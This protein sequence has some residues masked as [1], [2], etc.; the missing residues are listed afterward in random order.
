[1]KGG[2]A[3][4]NSNAL[5]FD[6]PAQALIEKRLDRFKWHIRFTGRLGA[7]TIAVVTLEIAT[8]GNIDFHITVASGKLSPQQSRDR[9][10]GSNKLIEIQRH[11]LEGNISVH[12]QIGL[13]FS[14]LSVSIPLLPETDRNS[15]LGPTHGFC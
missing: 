13:K 12:G 8:V 5:P 2:L 6:C 14:S 7:G 1:M 4:Q 9:F 11:P 10:L 3:A 15:A